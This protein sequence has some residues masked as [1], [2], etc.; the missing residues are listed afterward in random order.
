MKSADLH[1]AG[2]V[3]QEVDWLQKLGWLMSKWAISDF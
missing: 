2:E 3:N 1:E